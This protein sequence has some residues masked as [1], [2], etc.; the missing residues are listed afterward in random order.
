MKKMAKYMWKIVV[1]VA[2][3]ISMLVPN[4]TAIYATETE[5]VIYDSKEELF[6]AIRKALLPREKVDMEFCMTDR[7]RDELCYYDEMYR[8]YFLKSQIVSDE[9]VDNGDGIIYD[10][11]GDQ[12]GIPANEGEIGRAHV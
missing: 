12:M 8:Q 1:V 9:L 2:L 5:G 10:F 3:C 4:A 11:N 6:S 7:L